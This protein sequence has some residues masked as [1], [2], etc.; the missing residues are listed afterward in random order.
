MAFKQFRLEYNLENIGPDEDEFGYLT[1]KVCLHRERYKFRNNAPLLEYLKN[2]CKGF[3][4]SNDQLYSANYIILILFVNWKY[5]SRL[6]HWYIDL[7]DSTSKALRVNATQLTIFRIRRIVIK[8]LIAPRED[9]L[10]ASRIGYYS[11]PFW[12]VKGFRNLIN[13]ICKCNSCPKSHCLGRYFY[14]RCKDF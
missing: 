8:Q 4:E 5:K 7:D 1:Y 13:R 10:F 2:Q 11:T 3:I 12:C 6:N 14:Y 9:Q